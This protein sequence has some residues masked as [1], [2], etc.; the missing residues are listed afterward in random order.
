[1]KNIFCC[2]VCV[3]CVWSVAF[4]QSNVSAPQSFHI[5][6][7]VIPP[8]LDV[9]EGSVQFID[10]DK[11]GFINANE[12]C[13][14]RLQIK[15][16]GKGDGFGCVAKLS[17]SGTTQGL[18]FN[19]KQL[20]VIKPNELVW[21]E[22][23]ISASMNTVTGTVTFTLLVDEPNGFGTSATIQV[24]TRA[25]E[26]PFVEVA[27]YQVT[28]GN[29][30]LLTKRDPFTLQVMVQNTG[31]GL[32]E[33]VKVNVSFPSKNSGIFCT[34]GNDEVTIPQIKS[35]KTQIIEYQFIANNNYTPTDLPITVQ[36]SEKY[37]KYAKNETM[38]LNRKQRGG[39]CERT[40]GTEAGDCERQF[41]QRC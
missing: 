17:A 30:G 2:L 22:I 41:F 26:N 33:N 8:I 5:V 3:L 39:K 13:K 21:V 19:T 15:N 37:G 10:E 14:I 1:M 16:R 11:N 35:G 27:S 4:A 40:R 23:P 18:S 24:G 25:F 34:S 12:Q 32:A 9:V 29:G 38:N 36:I 7:Q 31:Y 28:G 6:K 20:A